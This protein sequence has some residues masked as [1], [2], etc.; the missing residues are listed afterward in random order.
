MLATAR[1]CVHTA[2]ALSTTQIGTILLH[3][4]TYSRTI[5][6]CISQS[7]NNIK[8]NEEVGNLY[9]F[10]YKFYFFICPIKIFFFS[11][12]FGCF[13]HSWY[14]FLLHLKPCY[15][16]LDCPNCSISIPCGQFILEHYAGSV[17]RS[18]RSNNI[19]QQNLPPNLSD[20][21]GTVNEHST[22]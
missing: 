22:I 17:D 14:L 4:K 2:L 20:C 19:L 8:Q 10:L 15:V 11:T 18:L 9:T 3:S 1:L 13:W 6:K 12:I 16:Y 5:S 21:N 7:V